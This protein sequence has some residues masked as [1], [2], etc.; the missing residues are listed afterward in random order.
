MRLDAAIKTSDTVK[1]NEDVSPISA[2]N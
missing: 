1:V 2:G